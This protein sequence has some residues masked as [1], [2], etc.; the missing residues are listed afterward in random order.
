MTRMGETRRAKSPAAAPGLSGYLHARVE[1]LRRL[2]PRALRASDV[3][4]IHHARVT[5]RRLKAAIDLLEPI[6]PADRR[7]FA[8][9]LRRLRRALGPL[10]DAD[11]IIGHLDEFRQTPKHEAAAAW[12]Q[13]QFR[14]ERLE[15]R[16]TCA[17]EHPLNSVLEDLGSWWSVEQDVAEAEGAVPSLL[18]R[19][20]PAQL[21]SFAHRA[22]R[23][24]VVRHDN[25]AR[26]EGAEDIHAL[27]IAGKLLRYTLEL[28]E[29]AGF[30][31]PKG[32]LRAFKTL[33][34]ALGGW[35]DFAVLS[36]RVVRLAIRREL[37]V[38]G[39]A[40]FGQV[41]ELSLAAWKR[42]ERYLAEFTR[43]WAKHG[44]QIQSAI[45]ETFAVATAPPPPPQP[46]ADA[47]QPAAS[48]TGPK[49]RRAPANNRPREQLVAAAAGATR[50]VNASGNR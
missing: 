34:D 27:R 14:Q 35:H 2:V 50:T 41:L 40:L 46:A 44:P 13:E 24:G 48:G 11:V 43:A 15:H 23:I 28:S 1:D 25:A 19:A 38:H 8:K 16:R 37:P 32:V 30:Q 4:A 12:L 47:Q 21:Q 36:E 6:L 17:R 29:P 3:T 33:Q 7:R 22:E 31:L 26:A 42:S 18:R 20:A 49:P 10:R 5:T 9:S 39:G 45:G